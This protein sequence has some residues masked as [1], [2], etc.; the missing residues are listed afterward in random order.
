MNSEL[1]YRRNTT[2]WTLPGQNFKGCWASLDELNLECPWL[3][4]RLFN[5]ISK[6]PGSH[7]V[8]SPLG[9]S[10]LF[11]EIEPTGTMF[12]TINNSKEMMNSND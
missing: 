11:V 8:E 9:W 2:L 4:R 1:P 7:F 12:Q 5:R 10:P 6:V 3:F